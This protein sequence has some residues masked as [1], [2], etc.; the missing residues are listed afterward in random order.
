MSSKYLATALALLVCCAACTT[1]PG[2]QD[3]TT[4]AQTDKSAQSSP[5]T[6]GDTKVE[7]EKQPPKEVPKPPPPI[8]LAEGT[9]FNIYLA[10]EISSKKSKA[11]DLFSGTLASPIAQGQH[12]VIP[13]GA[14]V[15]GRVTNA[16]AAGKFKGGASLG[17]E[18]RA[19]L[20]HG[21]TYMLRTT[22]VT[23]SS[24][25]KGKRTAGMV[26]G[27]A[28]G[29]AVI[30]G[31]AGGGKGAAI[32]AAV[33]TAAGVA[34]AGLTGDRDITV[35]VETII[36]FKLTDPVELKPVEHAKPE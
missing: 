6:P 13:E 12:V 36:S 10:Q 28:G 11:G 24:Q 1:K 34:G 35:P 15:T 18:L 32:G 14:E 22:M 19:V 17:L 29:G 33:G 16:K 31:I 7:P 30:G 25:G 2:T 5:A 3:Q 4:Q 21:D 23:T 20:V 26:A 27:G 9:V 8:V